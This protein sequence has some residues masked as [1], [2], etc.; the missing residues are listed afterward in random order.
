MHAIKAGAG[1]GGLTS[2]LALARRGITVTIVDQAAELGEVGAGLQLGPN[3]VKVL[4]A[5]GLE[6]EL[7]AISFAPEAAEV[8]GRNSGKLL[9]RNPLG[10]AASRRW[11]APYLQVHRADLQSILLEAVRQRAEISLRLGVKACG[12]EVSDT[13]AALLLED[14]SRI[15]GDVLVGCDGVRS[16]VRETLFGPEAPR[17]TGQVAWRG[18]VPAERLPRGLVP[19]TAGVWTGEGKHFVHYY[20]R[21]GALVN[22]VGVVERDWRKEGW[23]E[24]GDPAEL[25]ADFAGWPEPVA[26]LCRNVDQPFRWAL[27]GRAPLPQWSKGRATLLGDA[28]HPMLPFLAQGAAMAI[29]DAA[30]LAHKLTTLSDPTAALAAYERE[31]KPRTSKVQAW[32]A[33]NAHLFHLSEPMA[34]AAFNAAKLVD[35]VTPGGAAARFDWLYGYNAP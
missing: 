16:T 1:I 27:Y 13:S 22:F 33:R 23:S 7:K 19:P 20:L 9:L 34:A 6:A 29:E 5:L 2:A 24:P 18:V 14:G 30:V 8:R 3:A 10:A 17:F 21:G 26:S 28:C 15:A 11:G 31:R 12:V 4:A 35:R 25:Q 32:S